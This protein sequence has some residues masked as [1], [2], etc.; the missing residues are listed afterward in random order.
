MNG[1]IYGSTIDIGENAFVNTNDEW[2]LTFTS[3]SIDE[4]KAMAYYP[5][6]LKENQIKG[7]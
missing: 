2:N 6:G 3:K 4:I 1:T 5:W 7:L